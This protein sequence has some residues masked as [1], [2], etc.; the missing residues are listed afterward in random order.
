MRERRRSIRLLDHEDRLLRRLYLAARIPIDQYE[1]R[2]EDLAEFHRVWRRHSQRNDSPG[3]LIHYMRTK[4]KNSQW[5]TFDG[6]HQ[7]YSL[8]AWRFT[9][10]EID[11]AIAIY[12]QLLASTGRGS[13]NFAYD[14]GLSDKLSAEFAKR[15]GRVVPGLIISAVIAAVRKRGNLPRVDGKPHDREIGFGDID[16]MPI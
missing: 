6:K 9:P 5:V 16:E 10:D 8:V 15:A 3:E 12:E 13:D 1:K 7:K 11:T 4:R 14:E 2:P